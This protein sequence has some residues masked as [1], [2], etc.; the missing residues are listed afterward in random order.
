[1][2]RH[3]LMPRDINIEEVTVGYDWPLQEYFVQVFEYP[4]E[5]GE[6]RLLFAKS[7]PAVAASNHTPNTHVW[8]CIGAASKFAH[9]PPGLYAELQRDR[10]DQ[11]LCNRTVRW[12]W[13]ATWNNH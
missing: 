10:G 5:D 13:R 8:G 6:E 11:K 7:F 3:W 9:I 4:A 2:S 1:M 12:H